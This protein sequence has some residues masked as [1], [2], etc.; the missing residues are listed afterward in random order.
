LSAS[1]IINLWSPTLE[2]SASKINLS[3]ASGVS[4]N[5]PSNAVLN[6]MFGED[7]D[8]QIS[9]DKT[10]AYYFKLFMDN[11][12]NVVAYLESNDVIIN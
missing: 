10:G 11:I 9:L 8:T 12:Q 5:L 6:L 3:K 1:E 7:T 2:I 4:L